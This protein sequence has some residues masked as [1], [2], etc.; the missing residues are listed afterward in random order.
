M[1]TNDAVIQE[2]AIN[3]RIRLPAKFD[4]NGHVIQ[5]GETVTCGTCTL[6]SVISAAVVFAWEHQVHSMTV[7]GGTIVRH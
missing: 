1:A 2:K 5:Y 3:R 6:P 4:F 7:D